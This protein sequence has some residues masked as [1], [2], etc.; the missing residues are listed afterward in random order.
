MTTRAAK[1]P[2]GA[3]YAADIFAIYDDQPARYTR[4]NHGVEFVTK[5]AKSTRQQQRRK[6]VEHHLKWLT[7][8]LRLQDVDA[9]R[10]LL[11]AVER[12]LAADWRYHDWDREAVDTIRLLAQTLRAVVGPDPE[13]VRVRARRIP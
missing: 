12:E 11:K 9:A 4:D 3:I 6:K 13:G 8:G 10:G 1:H 7:E 2:D 5:A